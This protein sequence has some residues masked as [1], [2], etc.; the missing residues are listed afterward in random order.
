MLQ[1]DVL[2]VLETYCSFPGSSNR[3]DSTAT[4][5]EI[6]ASSTQK[7]SIDGG[8]KM[9]QFKYSDMLKSSRPEFL[10]CGF[11]EKTLENL[12][13]SKFQPQQGDMTFDILMADLTIK[14]TKLRS[15][16]YSIKVVN[17]SK[18]AV[19]K[20]T[21]IQSMMQLFLNYTFKAWYGNLTTIIATAAN[22]KKH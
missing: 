10:S 21:R 9:N 12:V 18:R 22:G 13:I 14:L 3:R 8:E 5:A 2:E 7:T 4:V 19:W 15:I 20:E 1:P 6:N 16:I 11:D 17:V